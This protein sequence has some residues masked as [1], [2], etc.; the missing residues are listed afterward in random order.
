VIGIVRGGVAPPDQIS[1]D[2]DCE[3]AGAGQ[4]R[5]YEM[6]PIS[7]TEVEKDLHPV[8]LRRIITQN[9]LGCGG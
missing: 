8:Q 3:F 6:N 2:R 1:S 5:P 7:L 9:A 4:P